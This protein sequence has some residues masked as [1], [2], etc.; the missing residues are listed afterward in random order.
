M[1]VA[2][3]LRYTTAFLNQDAAL[4]ALVFPRTMTT[5][6]TLSLSAGVLL[7]GELLHRALSR[8]GVSRGLGWFVAALAMALLVGPS[9]GEPFK[10]L[11]TLVVLPWIGYHMGQELQAWSTP[12][13]TVGLPPSAV[14]RPA[15]GLV[16]IP[17]LA[18]AGLGLLTHAC[19]APAIAPLRYAG[20]VGLASAATAVPVL[21]ASLKAL[22]L[23]N[24]AWARTTFRWAVAS[25]AML[26]LLWLGWTFQGQ[27]AAGLLKGSLALL[28]FFV[29]LRAQRG[30]RW[31]AWVGPLGA[32]LIGAGSFWAHGPTLLLTT[33]WGL[34][35]QTQVTAEQASR[36]DR[37]IQRLGLPAYLA[38]TAGS[39]SLPAMVLPGLGW[40]AVLGLMLGPIAAKVGAGWWLAHRY[41][42]K[43]YAF[44]M[45]VA[46]N[47]RG[48]VELLLLQDAFEHHGL[49]AVALMALVGMS[50]VGNLMTMVLVRDPPGVGAMQT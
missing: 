6:T 27:S 43:P 34:C 39:W 29:L 38:V 20:W 46:L 45:A 42:P 30:Q 16:M 23:L 49:S 14:W 47:T 9:F 33:L 15:L 40:A 11:L 50:V 48:L 4:S 12:D 13:A 44:R 21:Y 28:G 25:D 26:G 10:I 41:G 36:R 32:L 1:G 24:R 31:A 18:G 37:W 35:V 3:P 2:R 17:L 8:L 7:G 22:D 5:L 19:L